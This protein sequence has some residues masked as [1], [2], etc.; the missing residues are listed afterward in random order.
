MTYRRDSRSDDESVPLPI[1]TVYC[2]E[3]DAV[4]RGRK[5]VGGTKFNR[6]G[7]EHFNRLYFKYPP[8]WKTSNIGEKIIG[9]RNMTIHWKDADLQFVLYVRK[10]KHVILRSK[11]DITNQDAI[12]ALDDN[13]LNNNMNIYA[14]PINI[15]ISSNDTWDDIKGKIMNVINQESLYSFMYRRLK[16]LYH[17]PNELVPR[18]QQLDQIK[19]NYY[20]MLAESFGLIGERLQFYLE[21]GDIDIVKSTAHGFTSLQFVSPQN[22]EDRHDFFIDFMI[23]T[24]TPHDRDIDST[25]DKL[26]TALGRSKDPS[27]LIPPDDDFNDPLS[28]DINKYDWF[29]PYTSDFFNIGYQRYRNTF[30]YVFKFHRQLKLMNVMSDLECEVAASFATQSNHNMIGRTIETFTPIKYYKIND[31]DDMFWVAFYDRDAMNI[32]IAFNANVIFT[33]D[34]VLLQNRKLIYT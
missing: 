18:L 23:T 21:P 26:Y 33:M 5:T 1:E 24:L 31:D 9:V 34:A 10:Y 2:S 7:V 32:P 16:A 15:R 11:D 28:T 3:V 19:D 4:L 30:D 12:D 6:F 13:T 22:D 27:F 29:D 25:Y 20:A 14:I 17:L 8:E